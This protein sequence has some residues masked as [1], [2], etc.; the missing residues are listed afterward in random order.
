M[1]QQFLPIRANSPYNPARWSRWATERKQQ[2]GKR[3]ANRGLIAP[4]ENIVLSL[5]RSVVQKQARAENMVVFE[6]SQSSLFEYSLQNTRHDDD[7]DDWSVDMCDSIAVSEI[8]APTMIHRNHYYQEKSNETLRSLLVS[9]PKA[10]FP[11]KDIAYASPQDDLALQPTK[12]HLNR[13]NLQGKATPK[14]RHLQNSNSFRAKATMRLAG[15]PKT[16]NNNDAS[17]HYAM[18]E[19]ASK[20]DKR[21]HQRGTPSR[22]AERKKKMRATSQNTAGRITYNG[23]P[24]IA[25]L[26]SKTKGID[27]EAKIQPTTSSALT[28]YS[29]SETSSTGRVLEVASCRLLSATVIPVQQLVRQY[30][31]RRAVQQRQR[32]VVTMQTCA[33]GW[34]V[35]LQVQR[36]HQSATKIQAMVRSFAIRDLYEWQIISVTVIQ[37]AFRGFAAWSNYQCDLLD[38]ITVQ[39]LWR[40][41]I[42]K[43][44]AKQ[45][46]WNKAAP[47]ILSGLEFMGVQVPADADKQL[48]ELALPS[49]E[50]LARMAAYMSSLQISSY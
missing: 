49:E 36:E 33:R 9:P 29:S 39:S 46:K 22:M 11:V 14:N 20:T 32:A 28:V 19:H 35:K 23:K 12:R 24:T 50:M 42:A 21:A 2:K 40:Q 34:L 5:S 10:S 37:S 18:V 15:T 7:D 6:E 45:A 8:T 41:K 26:P 13:S 30:L 1:S 4:G 3:E 17:N 16:N 47:L 44:E 38:I 25:R 27:D 43:R 48:T 31:A